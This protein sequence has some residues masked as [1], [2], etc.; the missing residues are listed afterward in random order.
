MQHLGGCRLLYFALNVR[1]LVF[2]CF[3]QLNYSFAFPEMAGRGDIA[4][5]PLLIWLCMQLLCY[6][7]NQSSPVLSVFVINC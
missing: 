2:Y 6:L 3:F 5:S 4:S 1:V 7:I